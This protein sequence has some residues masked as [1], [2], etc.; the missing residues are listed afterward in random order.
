MLY[1]TVTFT[2][3][4]KRDRNF[5]ELLPCIYSKRVNALTARSRAFAHQSVVIKFLILLC[6][7][8]QKQCYTIVFEVGANQECICDSKVELWQIGFVIE[9][10]ASNCREDFDSANCVSRP[11]G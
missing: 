4:R 6:C 5:V 1:S 11:V 9:L 7:Q 8:T 3:R 10:V 2:L